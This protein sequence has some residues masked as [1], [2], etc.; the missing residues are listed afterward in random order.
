MGYSTSFEGAFLITPPLSRER[1]TQLNAKLDED[2][3][4]VGFD[5]RWCDWRVSAD[6]SL[7]GWNG[8]EK[9]YSMEEWLIWLVDT[10]LGPEGHV[11]NG[12]VLAQG[13]N[14]NDTWKLIA[15][16]NFVT[17]LQGRVTFE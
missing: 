5:T 2:L 8:S 13:E 3:Y 1:A 17:R 15:S 9:S 16:D 12:E 11:L 7:L 6:G 10:V 4:E 14:H